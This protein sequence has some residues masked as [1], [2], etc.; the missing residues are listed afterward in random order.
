V[1]PNDQGSTVGVTI[2]H[3]AR[4]LDEGFALAARYTRQILIEEFIPGRE[5]TVG[6]LGDEALPIVEII[7][8]SGFYDYKAKYTKGESRYEVPARLPEPQAMRIRE[9]GRAAFHALGCEGFARVDFRLHPDGT[10]YCLELNSI[11]GMTELS[12]FPMAARAVGIEYDAL[13]E[14]IVRLAVEKKAAPARS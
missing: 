12:L 4:E 14:Q 6:V 7:P 13:V 11:P 2:A 9:L 5:L 3:D 1:K 10:P 8:E